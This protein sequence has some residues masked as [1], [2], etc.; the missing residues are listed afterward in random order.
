MLI[1]EFRIPLPM[2]ANEYHLAQL[3]MVAKSSQEETGNEAGEG[4]EIVRNEAFTLDSPVNERSMPPGQYTEKIMHL[5]S[6]LPKM[7]AMMVPTSMTNVREKSYN[8][9]P[10]CY[11]EYYN[12]FFGEKFHLSVETMHLDDRG[13][14]ENAVKLVKE[15]LQKRKVDYINISCMDS[16]QKMVKGEDPT[17]FESRKTARGP[18]R[19]R[20]FEDH[21]PIM[22]C[23][24]VVKL[25][26]KVFGMQTKVEQWGMQFGIR[27]PFLQYHRKLVCWMDEWFGL[28]LND[29]RAM[30]KETEKITTEKLRASQAKTPTLANK[31]LSPSY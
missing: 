7:L 15:D 2:T 22:T 20:F 13:T 17:Q 16:S 23:Y 18:F 5:K 27:N 1:K 25:R 6:K 21:D 14:Q 4:I 3:Y 11:T 30:E 12:D 31:M 28:S 29:I 26:F 24:K 9:F 8:S 19:T 10:H